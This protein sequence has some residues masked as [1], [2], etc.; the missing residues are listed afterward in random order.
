MATK[1]KNTKAIIGFLSFLLSLTAM[2]SLAVPG[3]FIAFNPVK[4]G[5]YLNDAFSS[6]YQDTYRFK[7]VMSAQL[8][9]LLNNFDRKDE[10]YH[11]SNDDPGKNMLIQVFHA[12]ELAYS[13]YGDSDLSN[14]PFPPNGY[15][16]LLSFD[17]K[18]VS[19]IKDNTKIDVYG[20]NRIYD[21]NQGMWYLPGYTNVEFTGRDTSDYKINILAKTQP[22]K[23][24]GGNEDSGSLYGVIEYQG[25]L[26]KALYEFCFIAVAGI[27]FFVLYF[28]LRKNKKQT[29]LALARFSHYFWFEFKG[30]CLLCIAAINFQSLNRQISSLS[31]NS[32]QLDNLIPFGFLIIV[33]IFCYYIV[34]NDLRYNP[35]F[36]KN[37]SIQFF[38]S[39]YRKLENGNSVQKQLILR[40]WMFLGSEI[41]ILLLFILILPSNR[42]DRFPGF[43]LTISFL[44]LMFYLLHRYSKKFGNTV[45]EI[46]LLIDQISFVK[47][48]NTSA[49]LLLPNDSDLNC[50]ASELNEIQSGI[51]TAIEERLKSERMKIDLITNV[52]HDIKTPLTSIIGYIDLLKQEDDLPDHIRDYVQV[53]AEKSDRLKNMVQDI[54]EVSKATSGNIELKMESL[55][56]AKLLR[57]TLADMEERIEASGLTFKADIPEFAVMI[58]A[59]GQRLYRVFQNLIENALQYS[60]DGS[61]IYVSLDLSDNKA[62]AAIKNISRFELNPHLDMTERFVRGDNSRTDTGSGLGLSIAKSFT[63]ACGGSFRIQT[64]ADLF[65]AEVEFNQ[66]LIDL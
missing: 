45:N 13:D 33:S 16:F 15:N 61:R 48:G 37:N 60:L 29:D 14:S 20:K 41:G 55:D 62:R 28:F 11:I 42:L 25:E 26:R 51:D 10:D 36:Y 21:P 40:F 12:H 53:L 43:F 66:T 18:N 23:A 57:Q 8:E 52:S 2:C 47:A 35:K 1:W 17:G 3:I 58:Y 50:A 5:Q 4:A 30:F 9:E 31:R 22:T 63:E 27:L 54:F 49:A 64:D 19:I 46:G 59:D 44:I 24:Y 65:T 56:L 38:L 34:I 32:F 7:I 6:N 39:N